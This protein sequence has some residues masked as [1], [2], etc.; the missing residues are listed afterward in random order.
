MDFP[1]NLFYH[2][3][4]IGIHYIF[5]L[6]FPN[7]GTSISGIIFSCFF[8]GNTLFKSKKVDLINFYLLGLIVTYSGNIKLIGD[9]L[10]EDDIS[11]YPYASPEYFSKASLIFVL[12]NQI[13]VLGYQSIRNIKIP[14]I[15]YHISLSSR[16][17]EKIFFLGLIFTFKNFWLFFSLPGSLQTILDSIP[18]ISIFILSKYAGRLNHSP[19]YLL[20]LILTASSTFN[21]FM[22]AYLRL[23][24]I[25]PTIVFL[26]GY[27]V[28]SKS[29]KSFFSFKFLPVLFV[30][31]SFLAFFS[32]FGDKRSQLSIGL[33]RFSELF[34]TNDFEGYV[35]E[36]DDSEKL[37]AF[38]RA[39][40]IAQL[41]AIVRLVEQNGIYNGLAS[42]PLLGA[43]IPRFLWPEKPVVALG[44][45][46][47]VEIDAATETEDWY[48]NSV[49]MTIPGNLYLDFGWFGIFIG[50]L[51]IGIFLKL[52]WSSTGF[53]KDNFNILGLFLGVYLLFTCFL[54]IGADLQ[55]FITYLAI[56]LVLLFI[57][58]IINSFDENSMHRSHL[59]RK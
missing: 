3:F 47:A 11:F 48:N 14:P 20:A 49:N 43:L 28:G 37:S 4:W 51:I 44:V 29:F 52:L 40:N 56:Y 16:N 25:L 33:N 7:F 59:E 41:S 50:S 45:W 36:E 17:L 27:F 30:I 8:L 10:V 19:F 22:F 53:D 12:A 1:K 58:I 9:F 26:L 35:L 21:A 24:I 5:Y 2:L 23:D 6:F 42:S 46:F 55:I 57:T 38:E 13:I 18:I 32:F 54:G 15:Q 39:S 31:L 34:E